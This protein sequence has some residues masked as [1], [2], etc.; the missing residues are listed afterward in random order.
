MSKFTLD[1]NKKTLSCS[2]RCAVAIPVEFQGWK[3]QCRNTKSQI[4][5][6]DHWSLDRPSSP[7]VRMRRNTG[8]FDSGG[9]TESFTA[10]SFQS[11]PSSTQKNQ[12]SELA[13]LTTFC[14]STVFSSAGV[15][16]VNLVHLAQ[17]TQ[18]A[19]RWSRDFYS[20][21][22]LFKVVGIFALADAQQVYCD[23]SSK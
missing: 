18:T 14:F 7:E 15:T 12:T 3:A 5:V 4:M 1:Y 9:G 2:C 8:L 6:E 19:H 11:N 21:F 17:F 16:L 20:F 13:L 23:A 10:G 22:Y